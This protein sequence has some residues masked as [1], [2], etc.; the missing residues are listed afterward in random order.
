MKNSKQPLSLYQKD[1]KLE[2]RMRELNNML[3]L[4]QEEISKPLKVPKR[5]T[6]FLLGLPRSGH[7]L[8]AQLLVTRFHLAYPTNFIARLWKVPGLVARIQRIALEPAIENYSS[9]STQFESNQGLTTGVYGIHEFGYFWKEIFNFKKTHSLTDEEWER[10]NKERLLRLVAS[11]EYEFGNLPVL[12]KNGQLIFQAARLSRLFPKSVF[13]CVLRDSLYVAQSLAINRQKRF[14]NRK[15]WFSFRPPEY[16]WLKDLPWW[17]QIGGQ[18]VYIKH[19]LKKQMEQIPSERVLWFHYEKICGNSKKTMK[20]IEEFIARH[21]K[22]LKIKKD[23]PERF[24]QRN[25]WLLPQHDLE[26]FKKSLKKFEE[27]IKH[28]SSS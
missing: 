16:S 17:E 2:K 3:L 6:I 20:S 18:V 12:F 7:T 19:H 14:G 25:I 27:N 24:T 23:V 4:I 1:E 9:D 28:S 10:V 21:D 13:I 5:P 15:E 11:L 26:L 22:P 8:L